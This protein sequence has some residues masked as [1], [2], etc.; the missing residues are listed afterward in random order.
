MNSATDDLGPPTEEMVPVNDE[1]DATDEAAGLLEEQA[2]LFYGG[3]HVKYL[4]KSIARSAGI[5]IATIAVFIVI[6]IFTPSGVAYLQLTA[7]LVLIL[8][9][10][11]C[12]WSLQRS[13]I[14][15]CDWRLRITAAIITIEFPTSRL[16]WLNYKSP[17]IPTRKIDTAELEKRTIAELFIF[18]NSRTVTIDTAANEDE[19]FH[20]MSDMKD[21][22]LLKQVV[23]DLIIRIHGNY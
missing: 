6:L 13:Y 7:S 21:P 22:E 2:G 19:V 17:M 10:I 15:W 23:E 16:F 1:L 9:L 20:N 12:W 5:A 4:L 8:V 14:Y 11:G 3:K 18:R